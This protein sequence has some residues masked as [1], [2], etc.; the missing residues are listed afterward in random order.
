MQRIQARSAVET[1][2][3]AAMEKYDEV[4]TLRELNRER[5]AQE[6]ILPTLAACCLPCTWARLASMCLPKREKTPQ[7]VID[8]L[9]VKAEQA[10]QRIDVLAEKLSAEKAGPVCARSA[11]IAAARR[12][13]SA[14]PAAPS[15]RG[16]G[17]YMEFSLYEIFW[18]FVIY[19]VLGWVVEVCFCSINTGG[20]ETGVFERPRVPHLRLWHGGGAGVPVAPAP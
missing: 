8:A 6:D 4:K 14:R 17:K 3:K 7:Q 5:G 16:R 2:G 13:R 11:A 9:L 18:Y 10:Q 12:T 15:C 1:A 19:A 20:F